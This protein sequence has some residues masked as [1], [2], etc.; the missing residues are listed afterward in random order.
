[1]KVAKIGPISLACVSALP[2]GELEVWEGEAGVIEVVVEVDAVVGA[3]VD[4]DAASGA[5]TDSPVDCVS[6]SL[7]RAAL[8]SLELSLRALLSHATVTHSTVSAAPRTNMDTRRRV[9]GEKSNARIR[10]SVVD[11]IS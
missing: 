3:V 11:W 4:V 1:M 2:A 10:L 5:G 7:V 8:F 9:V 6:A